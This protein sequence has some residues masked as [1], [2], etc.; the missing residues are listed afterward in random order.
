LAE[1]EACGDAKS[2]EVPGGVVGARDA[3][4]VPSETLRVYVGQVEANEGRR[5]DQ[6]SDEERDEI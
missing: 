6:L 1:G 5:K 4:G 2:E 3:L